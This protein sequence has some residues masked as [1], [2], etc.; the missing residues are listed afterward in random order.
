M[1]LLQAI[2]NLFRFDRANWK[3]VFL[4]FLTAIVFWLFNAFNKNYATNVKFPLHFEYN[5]EFFVSVKALP[6]Q[7][8]INVT[9]NGW[10][11][12]RNH[13]GLKIPELSITLERPLEIKKIVGASLPPVFS[14]QVGKLHINYIVT[15]TLRIQLDEKDAHRFKVVI[16]LKSISFREGFGRTS[17]IVILPDSVELEGPKS[18][19]H[20]MD[21]ILISPSVSR[22][23]QNFNEDIEVPLEEHSIKRNPPLVKVMFE[24]GPVVVVTKKLK[25]IV[26]NSLAAGALKI[27]PDSIEGS[28]RI[29]V[30]R[31][32]EFNL[33]I[34]EMNAEVD[35]RSFKNQNEVLPRVKKASN[36]MEVIRLDSI[37][38]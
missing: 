25:L 28:F 26:K 38:K 15:D 23:D 1:N 31:V 19:L 9:G 5:H 37:R 12:F 13:L 27:F 18:T 17:P 16:D 7:V 8:S 22:L 2:V 4:C 6:S 24:V 36:Y 30:K 33:L 10:D 3:A 34:K 20:E 21:S 11:L 32:E 14:P 29:P 35:G